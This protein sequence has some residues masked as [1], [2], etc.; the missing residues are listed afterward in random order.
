MTPSN[1]AKWLLYGLILA[2][3]W[4]PRIRL[5]VLPGENVDIRLQ[6]P[7]LAV[8][9]VYLLLAPVAPVR[10]R[11]DLV[12]GRWLAAF[13]YIATITTVVHVIIGEPVSTLVRIAYLGRTI[14]MFFLAIAVCGLYL[15]AGIDTLNVGRVL[16]VGLWVNLAW[17]AYQFLT[18]TRV[19]LFG[20]FGQ[21]AE[22]YGPKLIGEPSAFGTGI[23]L[24]AAAALTIADY[25]SGTIRR[26][27]ALMTLVA[28]IGAAYLVESR[29]NLLIILTML[30]FLSRR[31]LRSL[32]SAPG[33]S[34]LA[35]GGIAALL[36]WGDRLIGRFSLGALRDGFEIRFD[37][38]GLMAEHVGD[39]FIIG[40]GP[41]GLAAEGLSWDEAHNFLVRAWL[42]FGILGAF[43]LLIILGRA[44]LAAIRAVRTNGPDDLIWAATL[45]GLTL[46]GVL[47]AGMVQDSL[48]AVTSTHLLMIAL[49]IFTAELSKVTPL[50]RLIPSKCMQSRSRTDLTGPPLRSER[51][52]VG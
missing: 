40:V 51:A 13:L 19:T 50:N 10:S 36:L 3:C 18:G 34:F 16:R 41:G 52:A 7:L 15:R 26:P 46:I 44:L 22:S 17:I 21:V 33:M 2:V 29:V 28:I 6:D 49:G 5:D 35:L 43:I 42:D 27:I 4:S 20:D 8:A 30:A 1:A 25:R 12:W 11:W 47:G 32:L 9:L 31:N 48:T 45:A 24:T 37:I 39:L 38:W 23:F 14:E